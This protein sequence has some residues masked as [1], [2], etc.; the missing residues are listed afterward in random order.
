MDILLRSCK[1]SRIQR[2]RSEYICRKSILTAEEVETRYYGNEN[3]RE[4][5]TKESMK[6]DQAIK[7]DDD[8]IGRNAIEMTAKCD[9]SCSITILTRQNITKGLRNAS[10][11][12]N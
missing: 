4:T 7:E 9:A 10:P 11:H 12:S 6:V 8:A 2:I 3:K 5:L 1:V